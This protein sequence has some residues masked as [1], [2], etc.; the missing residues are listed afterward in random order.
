MLTIS[1]LGRI[2]VPKHKYKQ[3][4]LWLKEQ[5]HKIGHQDDKTILIYFLLVLPISSYKIFELY[6]F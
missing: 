6:I 3:T 2:N 1:R 5:W 4:Y